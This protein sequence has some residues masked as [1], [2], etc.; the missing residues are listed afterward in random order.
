MLRIAAGRYLLPRAAENEMGP[1]PVAFLG[2]PNGM[3]FILRPVRWT[4]GVYLR[5]HPTSLE[6]DDALAPESRGGG[7]RSQISGSAKRTLAG[8]SAP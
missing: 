2:M 7:R 3:C 5:L 8:L 6:G 4:I 1:A